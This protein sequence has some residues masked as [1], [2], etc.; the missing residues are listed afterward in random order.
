MSGSKNNNGGG[1]PPKLNTPAW[2]QLLAGATILIWAALPTTMRV[3]AFGIMLALLV[4]FI[5][6]KPALRASGRSLIRSLGVRYQSFLEERLKEA[7][8][9]NRDFK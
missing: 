4:K 3:L 9:M 2:M 8:L 1:K 5:Q 6:E 7:R